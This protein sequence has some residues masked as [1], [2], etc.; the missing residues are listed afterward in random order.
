VGLLH[1]AK[2]STIF[3]CSNLVIIVYD[4]IETKGQSPMNWIKPEI[5]GRKPI[6][7]Y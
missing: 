4:F 5:L 2:Y 6:G 7:R 1:K 3:M